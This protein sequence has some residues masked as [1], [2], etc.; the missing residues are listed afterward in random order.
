MGSLEF[1][2]QFCQEKKKKKKRSS[3][4]DQKK[5]TYY[6]AA[7][8]KQTNKQSTSAHMWGSDMS[9]RFKQRKNW[10]RGGRCS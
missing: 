10:G 5:E 2:P 8:N 9:F 4:E 3:G 6:T 1:K 7:E